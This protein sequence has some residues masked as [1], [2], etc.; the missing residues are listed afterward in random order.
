MA[1]VSSKNCLRGEVII[2][3][4]SRGAGLAGKITREFKDLPEL[5]VQVRVYKG[6]TLQ[7]IAQ[8]KNRIR[9]R[10]DL[11]VIAAGVCNFTERDTKNGLRIL[12]YSNGGEK[13]REIKETIRD[14]VSRNCIVATITPAHLGNYAVDKNP[15]NKEDLA[16]QIDEQTE[17]LQDIQEVNEFIIE[18]SKNKGSQIL[19]L[20]KK[21]YASSRKRR[22]TKRKTVYTLRKDCLPDGVHLSNTLRKEWTRNICAAIKRYFSQA[23]STEEESTSEEET[24]NFKRRR[25][26]EKQ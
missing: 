21:A 13:K 18:E 7:R 19:N 8:A 20:A 2:L 24:G 25:K 17:L 4:D 22:G 16:D 12:S 10:F 23:D 15:K 11:C 5:N 9:Q 3:T 1:G 6:A 26:E 14:L